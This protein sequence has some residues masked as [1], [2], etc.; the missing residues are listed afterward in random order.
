[1]NGCNDTVCQ[2]INKTLQQP[3]EKRLLHKSYA[4]IAAI[5][6]GWCKHPAYVSMSDK[7]NMLMGR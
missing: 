1:M 6:S 4:V 5:A 7:K 3:I 2:F